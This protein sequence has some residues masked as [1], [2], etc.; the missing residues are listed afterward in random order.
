MIL[1]LLAIGVIY[2]ILGVVTGKGLIDAA[3]II[4]V[5]VILILAEV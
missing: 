5:I 3:T 4:A 1:L 2:S